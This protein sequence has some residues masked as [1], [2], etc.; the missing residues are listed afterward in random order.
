MGEH[1]RASSRSEDMTW[2]SVHFIGLFVLGGF[3]VS[4]YFSVLK[5]LFY[6]M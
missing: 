5:F 6:F 3:L 2:R 4:N 1:N